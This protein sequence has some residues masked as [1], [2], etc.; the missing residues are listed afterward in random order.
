MTHPTDISPLTRTV[1]RL[2]RAAAGEVDP[3]LVPSHFPSIDRAIGG[4]FRRGDLVVMGGDDSAGASALA[5]AIALRIT[6]RALLLTGEMPAERAYERAL[7]MGAK[8]PLE[9]LRLGVVTDVERARLGAA[10]VM[11][12][13]RAPV[14]DT[15]TTGAISAVADALQG[16]PDAPLVVVDPLECL[17]ARDAGRDEALGYAVLSLKRLALERNVVV[18]LTAHLPQLDQSRLDRRPRLT[19]FGL[20]G[21][22][23]THADLV[24]GLYREELYEA[25][26][27]VSGAAELRVLKHRDGATGYIDLYFDRRYC[28]FEDVLEE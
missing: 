26:L 16:T 19:D 12:R 28:R 5:L 22:I 6:P 4:G 1:S 17:L 20:G 9:S 18:L 27:G 15:L 10:A 8:V 14:I 23:G 21:A 3:G 13:D 24:L 11:L 2:D 7:A 25:D